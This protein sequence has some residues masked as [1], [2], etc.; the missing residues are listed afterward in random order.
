M[1]CLWLMSMALTLPLTYFVTSFFL[2]SFF[3]LLALFCFLLIISCTMSSM[4]DKSLTSPSNTSTYSWPFVCHSS[5]IPG[6]GPDWAP[7]VSRSLR[8]LDFCQSRWTQWGHRSATATAPPV[9]SSRQNVLRKTGCV[10]AGGGVSWD[11]AEPQT[12]VWGQGQRSVCK[13]KGQFVGVEYLGAIRSAGFNALDFS[14]SA[15]IWF[16]NR[17]EQKQSCQT[18]IKLYFD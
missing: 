3:F 2:S 9:Q 1:S 10:H 8:G 17:K 6:R 18:A 15:R 13:G 14:E 11:A 4:Q 5:A 16:C 7:A 12:G